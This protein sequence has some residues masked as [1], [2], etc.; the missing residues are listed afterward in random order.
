MKQKELAAHAALKPDIEDKRRRKAFAEA[1]RNVEPA[2]AAR[3]SA[4]E[5]LLAANAGLK[6]AMAAFDEAQTE[7]DAAALA[8]EAEQ[9]KDGERDARQ[10]EANLL[11]SRL[12][13]Y[14]ELEKNRQ[15]LAAAE[16][17]LAL[18]NKELESAEKEKRAVEAS[19]AE[20]EEWTAKT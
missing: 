18:A 6:Q 13:N 3:K 19:I 1:A 16:S 12:P 8:L 17:R 2:A 15:G 11:E 4:E 10:K 5:R 14:L 20:M 9:S 7:Y